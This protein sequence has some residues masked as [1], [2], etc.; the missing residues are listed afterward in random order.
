[1]FATVFDEGRY[2]VGTPI[3]HLKATVALASAHPELGPEFRAFLADFM[4]RS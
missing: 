3:E 4:K 1:V 2:D